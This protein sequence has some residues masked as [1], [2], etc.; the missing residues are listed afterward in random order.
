MHG[1]GEALQALAFINSV[2]EGSVGYL[3]AS[4]CPKE[5][6]VRMVTICLNM[7]GWMQP[8]K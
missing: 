8:S 3:I 6:G 2:D 5:A 7:Q 1:Y 4:R